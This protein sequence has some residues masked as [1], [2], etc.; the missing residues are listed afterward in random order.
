MVTREY[1][2]PGETLGMNC[3]PDMGQLINGRPYSLIKATPCVPCRTK[4][5]VWLDII[6]LNTRIHVA[7]QVRIEMK[8]THALTTGALDSERSVLT[9]I[10]GQLSIP[11]MLYMC[12]RAF[13]RERSP[14]NRRALTSAA[15]VPQGTIK[16]IKMLGV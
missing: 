7:P 10:Y 14:G 9:P 16:G 2:P 11:V 15:L 6:R 1:D 3:L 13:T 4:D 8:A 5:T 12:T